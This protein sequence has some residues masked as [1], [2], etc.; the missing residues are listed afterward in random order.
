MGSRAGA[1]RQMLLDLLEDP[2][3][4]RL[5]CIMGKNCTLKKGND[6]VECS[7][8]LEKQIA[9]GKDRFVRNGSSAYAIRKYGFS[10]HLILIYAEEEEEIEML[11]ENYLQRLFHG[12]FL[13]HAKVCLAYFVF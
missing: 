12:P 2:E 8:P 9:E 11:L 3:E 6:E 10:F 13:E 7:V 4:I 5:M 1:L